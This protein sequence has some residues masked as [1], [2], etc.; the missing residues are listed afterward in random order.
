VGQVNIDYWL[1]ETEEEMMNFEMSLD[2]ASPND[3]AQAIK[4]VRDLAQKFE[5]EP[6]DEIVNYRLA[7][8]RVLQ[9]LDGGNE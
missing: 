4:R 2:I 8:R 7:G 5:A 1:L 6:A 9:A 3:M